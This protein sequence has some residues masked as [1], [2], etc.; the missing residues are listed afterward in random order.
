MLKTREKLSIIWH[1]IL[2]TLH[3]CY[4]TYQHSKWCVLLVRFDFE[5]SERILIDWV[6]TKNYFKLIRKLKILF[7][8]ATSNILKKKKQTNQFWV[9]ENILIGSFRTNIITIYINSAIVYSYNAI[10]DNFIYNAKVEIEIL[11]IRRNLQKNHT[12]RKMLR[13][14]SSGSTKSNAK[15]KEREMQQQQQKIIWNQCGKC[16]KITA[17]RNVIHTGIIIK[18]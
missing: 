11:P 13:V 3:Q 1:L 17:I 15:S 10:D 16:S 8:Y 14:N 9:D 18:E 7:M 5:S 2:F 4:C 6:E 12:Y